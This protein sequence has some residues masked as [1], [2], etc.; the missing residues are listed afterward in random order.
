MKIPNSIRFALCAVSL[1]GVAFQGHA[2]SGKTVISQRTMSAGDTLQVAL[3]AE[4]QQGPA[5]LRLE[6]CGS[7]DKTRSE[8]QGELSIIFL[9]AKGGIAE[10]VSVVRNPKLIGDE[11][12]QLSIIPGSADGEDSAMIPAVLVDEYSRTDGVFAVCF[13]FKSD[14]SLEILAGADDY[15]QFAQMAITSWPQQAMIT[16]SAPFTID[17]VNLKAGPAVFE[18]H[19]WTLPD[20]SPEE[21]DAI[22]VTVYRYLD[23][24]VNNARVL[25]GG[26]YKLALKAN[27]KGGYSL[28]YIEGATKNRIAWRPGM[29]KGELSPTIFENHYDLSWRDA[30]FATDFDGAWGE[31]IESGAILVLHFP[32]EEAVL[33]FSRQD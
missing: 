19:S 26:D 4:N 11:E 32:H 16:S 3:G 12:T 25:R 31:L 33:R 15:Q 5:E 10:K 7:F 30:D 2:L 1:I 27:G 17:A 22:G 14:K 21:L 28:Y 29:S 8:R 24:E 20:C 6:V 13:D 18:G 9:D 23:N